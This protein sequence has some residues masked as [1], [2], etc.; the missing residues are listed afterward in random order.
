[1][2]FQGMKNK[3]KI[4]DK[5]YDIYNCSESIK[6]MQEY[7]VYICKYTGSFAIT[8]GELQMK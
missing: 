4:A 3:N 8:L 2:L 6:G 1:M 5:V 7:S